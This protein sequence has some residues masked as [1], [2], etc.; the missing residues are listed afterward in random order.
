MRGLP[1][2]MAA[3]LSFEPATAGQTLAQ[4]RAAAA[5][6]QAFAAT[7]NR[8]LL[9][10]AAIAPIPWIVT[11][12]LTLLILITVAM[13]HVDR[14]ITI[15]INLFSLATAAAASMVLLIVND[16]PFAVGGNKVQPS[17]LLELKGI[18]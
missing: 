10:K 7:R 15:F 8:L 9:S 18:D 6:E 17:A 16:S 3:L 14:P 1:E 2:V 5:L 11:F 13:I 12:L 4:Q